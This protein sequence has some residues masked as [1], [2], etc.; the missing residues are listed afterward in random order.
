MNDVEVLNQLREIEGM[1]AD[2]SEED[3]FA[4]M[5]YYVAAANKEQLTEA[6]QALAA[7]S[8]NARTTLHKCLSD[9]VSEPTETE[10]Q[11]DE[12]SWMDKQR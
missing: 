8:T 11:R 6:I 12:N 2:L 1:C 4:A 3:L 10:N 5:G 9:C 7:A